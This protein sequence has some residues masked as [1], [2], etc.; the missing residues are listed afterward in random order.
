MTTVA[1]K[2]IVAPEGRMVP[3]RLLMLVPKVQEE[4]EVGVDDAVALVIYYDLWLKLHCESSFADMCFEAGPR[5]RQVH[6]IHQDCFRPAYLGYC[7]SLFP[8]KKHFRLSCPSTIPIVTAQRFF[9]AEYG[10]QMP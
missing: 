6:V 5:I 8:V 2:K 7:R 4:L 3:D 9:E 10:M 1:E